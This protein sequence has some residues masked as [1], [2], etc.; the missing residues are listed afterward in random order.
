MKIKIS[1][2]LAVAALAL[3]VAS[4]ASASELCAGVTDVTTITAAGGCTVAGSSLLFNNFADFATGGA[5]GPVAIS[6]S[7]TGVVGSDV[8]LAFTFPQ[9]S[10]PPGTGDIQLSYS[11]S[12]GIEGVDMALTATQFV[13]GT[14]SVTVTEKVCTVAFTGGNCVGGTLLANYQVTST[15]Q[16]A[17]G[18]ALL[19]PS[20][21]GTV[22]IFKDIGFNGASTSELVNSQMVPEPMTFSL[23]GAGLLGLG[24]MG[25]RLRK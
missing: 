23:L 11:V 25:R 18:M 20:Y 14:G 12:G 7:G 8:D 2:V 13:P 17:T 22:W 24:L 10:F 4:T 21:T 9:V 1:G 3:G 15:G 16:L 5:S 19:N 6:P